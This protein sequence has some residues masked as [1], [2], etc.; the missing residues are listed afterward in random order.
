MLCCALPKFFYY[1]SLLID[2]ESYEYKLISRRCSPNKLLCYTRSSGLIHDLPLLY[3]KSELAN[4]K[5]IVPEMGT[6][7]VLTPEDEAVKQHVFKSH[8]Q[9]N[10]FKLLAI[11]SQSNVKDAIDRFIANKSQ[12][13]MLIP[14]NMSEMSG[15]VVNELR[16]MIE[17]AENIHS[18]YGKLFVLL[19]HFPPAMFTDACYPALFLQGWGHYYLDTLTIDTA[20][21][22][23]DIRDWFQQCCM[24]SLPLGAAGTDTLSEFLPTML[25]QQVPVLALRVS[26]GSLENSPFNK[27]M[28]QSERTRKL[29]G[30]LVGKELGRLLQA[31]FQ[32]YWDQSTMAKYL[33]RAAGFTR[34]GE[35]TLNMTDCLQEMLKSSFLDFLL[36]M[37]CR[38]NE[39]FNLDVLFDPQCPPSVMDLFCGIVDE[40]HTPKI[41]ELKVAYNSIREQSTQKKAGRYAPRFPFYAMI[42]GKRMLSTNLHHTRSAY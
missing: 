4:G 24:E 5:P 14:V 19:L 18:V 27:P 40:M 16:I 6:S 7:E 20:K 15:K 33:Q 1:D 13:I 25:E 42:S 39:N 11:H 38:M 3:P 35:S 28:P 37:L 41:S 23:V 26:F 9:V 32:R 34:N 36:Y 8:R 17:E 2:S 29:H 21:G 22:G 12:Q 30:L 10:V 31:L